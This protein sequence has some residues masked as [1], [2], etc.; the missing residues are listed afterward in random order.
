MSR[1]LRVLVSDKP[2]AATGPIEWVS[3]NLGLFDLAPLLE[4]A[5]EIFISQLIVQPAHK[6]LFFDTT[7]GLTLSVTAFLRPSGPIPGSTPAPLSLV[8]VARAF[9]IGRSI[10]SAPLSALVSCLLVSLLTL[11]LNRLGSSSLLP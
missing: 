4:M 7:N 1:N 11:G 5:H 2:K 10:P 3:Y 9:P 6:D 8:A